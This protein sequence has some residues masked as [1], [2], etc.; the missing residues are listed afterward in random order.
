LC[1]NGSVETNLPYPETAEDLIAFV[2]IFVLQLTQL[3]PAFVLLGF[4]GIGILVA[5]NG[6]PSR[7]SDGASQH[8]LCKLTW[9]SSFAHEIPE[10]SRWQTAHK[11][12]SL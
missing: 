8:R 4:G 7:G 1:T 12:L 11:T 10:L 5:L 6:K 3:A 2:I 9:A